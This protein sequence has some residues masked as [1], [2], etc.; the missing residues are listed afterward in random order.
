M[1]FTLSNGSNYKEVYI[2]NRKLSILV[3]LNGT[4]QIEQIIPIPRIDYVK[5]D[6]SGQIKVV[7]EKE[8][9]ENIEIN[10]NDRVHAWDNKIFKEI[11]SAERKLNIKIYK[12]GL[13]EIEKWEPKHRTVY[14]EIANSGVVEVI[15]EENYKS[16]VIVGEIGERK[17]V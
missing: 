11:T 7:S 15:S 2:D 6:S 5:I 16:R 4:I 3:Y 10:K 12:N 14:I 1:A 13:I 8:W 17:T 9:K